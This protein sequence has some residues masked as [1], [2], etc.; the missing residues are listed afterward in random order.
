MPAFNGRGN[1]V[2]TSPPS[3]LSSQSRKPPNLRLLDRWKPIYIGRFGLRALWTEWSVE[4]RVLSGALWKAPHCGAF[5]IAEVLIG[6][7]V[8]ISEARRPYL[9]EGT[10]T[11]Y[12]ISQRSQ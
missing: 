5:S 8:R 7:G 6:S 3:N 10:W 4:V 2:A 11:G 1:G 9:E 12:E